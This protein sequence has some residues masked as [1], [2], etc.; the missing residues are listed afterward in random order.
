MNPDDEIAR[1]RKD[2]ARYRWLRHGDNDDLVLRN[3]LG[4]VFILRNKE[5]DAAIDKQLAH[6]QNLKDQP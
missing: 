4:S 3:C 2:A 6:T 1:D 5:L